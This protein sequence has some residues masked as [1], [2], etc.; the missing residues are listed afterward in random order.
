MLGSMQAVPWPW[1]RRGVLAR[2]VDVVRVEVVHLVCFLELL[3]EVV[4][5]IVMAKL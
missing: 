4:Q 2:G 3:V 1:G 5:G